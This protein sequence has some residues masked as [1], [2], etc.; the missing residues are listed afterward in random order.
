MEVITHNFLKRKGKVWSPGQ[1]KIFRFYKRST[2][3][4]LN[5]TSSETILVIWEMT[6]VLQ[7]LGFVLLFNLPL[8]F[9]EIKVSTTGVYAGVTK[10]PNSHIYLCF[11]QNL[12]KQ[13]NGR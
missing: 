3:K 5:V 7:I 1:R 4:I 11:I 8:H 10:Y 2:L 12:G 6:P 9:R 13:I